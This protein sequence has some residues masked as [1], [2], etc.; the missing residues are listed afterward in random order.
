[1]K[2]RY[3]AE[4]LTRHE[5]EALLEA[6]GKEKWTDRRNYALIV[7]LWR[8]GLR[9]SEA[10]ALRPCDIDL[11]RGAIRVLRSKG[12]RAR[13]VGIDRS[14]SEAL[15]GWM[16]EHRGMGYS[17][18]EVLFITRSGLPLS[19][20][21]LRRKIPELSRAAGIHKRVHAHG[22]RHTH[23]SELRAEGVDIAVIKR[24]LGHRSLL[25]TVEYLDHLSPNLVVETVVARDTAIS[26]S[27]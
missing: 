19:Q 15:K 18:G 9:I 22:L 8:T 3:P 13:T 16:Q 17:S 4:V 14:G 25:T 21:Y 26:D 10:L 5:I 1:M 11:E 12:G 23:A 20:G 2:K 27:T 7:L 6:C 24:Q